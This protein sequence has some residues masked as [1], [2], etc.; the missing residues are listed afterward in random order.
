MSR[1][2]WCRIFR[3]GRS[4]KEIN[5]LSK[6]N[7]CCSSDVVQAVDIGPVR[8]MVAFET[9]TAAR[10]AAPSNQDRTRLSN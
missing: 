10:D 4:T 8:G 6:G 2:R 1:E 9:V 7:Q 3:H 5:S